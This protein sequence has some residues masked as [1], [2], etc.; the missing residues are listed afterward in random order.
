MD[1]GCG[2]SSRGHRAHRQVRTQDCVSAREYSGQVGRPACLHRRQCPMRS[3]AVLRARPACAPPIWP[4]AAITVEH[5][6]AKSEPATATGRRRPEASGS[7]SVMRWQV[8]SRPRPFLSEASPARRADRCATPSASADSTSSISAGHLLPAAAVED[9]HAS[10]R[11][12]ATAERAQSMA[13]LPPP[14]TT[15]SRPSEGGLPLAARSR[16]SM[17]ASAC[18]WPSQR[19]SLCA[20][21]SDRQ[22]D[23]AVALAQFGERE[24]SAPALRPFGTARRVCGWRRSPHRARPSADDRRGCRSAACRRAAGCASKSVQSWPFRSRY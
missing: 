10:A 17:P 19:E 4:M 5:S 2:D 8:S 11:L 9:A 1:R 22:E 16:N 6:M 20:L 3:R 13:V 24:I 21:R 18:S 14:T 15:T 7:P 23:R 12:A